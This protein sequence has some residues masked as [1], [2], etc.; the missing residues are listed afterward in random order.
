VLS[1]A[2]QAD[3]LRNHELS[4]VE[5]DG[6]RL[7]RVGLIA[8]RGRVR[9]RGG[10]WTCR[11]TLQLRLDS[12]A[13][14]PR[15][16]PNLAVALVLGLSLALGAV[17]LLLVRDVRKRASAERALAESLAFRKAWK[18]RSSPGLRASR[19]ERP[20]SPM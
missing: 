5:G 9:V 12:A 15:F 20:L 6:T 14:S 13:G 17:V 18:T 10:W 4:F 8:R 1:E 19:P 2:V 16:I 11:L 3:V 7:A